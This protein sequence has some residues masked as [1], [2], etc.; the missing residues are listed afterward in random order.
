[1]EAATTEAAVNTDTA[2]AVISTDT[3]T[4]ASSY[5]LP[6]KSGASSSGLTASLLMYTDSM[7]YTI[8]VCKH[9]ER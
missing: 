1:M 3:E 2:D 9:S 5:H 4:A 8:Q 7:L 6:Q